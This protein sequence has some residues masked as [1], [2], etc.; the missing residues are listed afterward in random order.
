LYIVIE[1]Y[2]TDSCIRIAN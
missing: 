2:N 1:L